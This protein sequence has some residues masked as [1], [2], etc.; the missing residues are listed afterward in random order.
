M[1]DPLNNLENLIV[2]NVKDL[3]DFTNALK[4][5][6]GSIELNNYIKHLNLRNLVLINIDVEG[7]ERKVFEVYSGLFIK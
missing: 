3:K 4:E 7:S 2:F 5:E 1:F 6:I